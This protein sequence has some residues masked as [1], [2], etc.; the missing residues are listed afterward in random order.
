MRLISQGATTRLQLAESESQL[1]WHEKT[2]DKTAT[3]IER[4]ATKSYKAGEI[5]YVEYLHGMQQ[6]LDLKM[7]H[8][9]ALKKYNQSVID[10]G[11]ISGSY[12]N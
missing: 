1:S 11:L 6:S 7:G 10:L 4:F 5:D 2:G 3:E 8:A 9:E 12:K